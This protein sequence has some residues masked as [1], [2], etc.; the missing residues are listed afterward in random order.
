MAPAASTGG[1]K[2]KKKWSKGKV[3]DKAKHE[4]VLEKTVAEKLNKDVQ[5]YRLITVSTLV[6]RH[7]INGSLARAVLNDLEERGVI[8]KVVGHNTLNIYTRAVTA[9]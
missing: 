8:K 1:K 2:Q 6:D 9:E 5:S 7:K 4:V 3:K